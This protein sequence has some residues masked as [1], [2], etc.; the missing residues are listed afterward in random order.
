MFTPLEDKDYE[1]DKLLAK[2]TETLNV[3]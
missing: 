2:F 1:E 3:E